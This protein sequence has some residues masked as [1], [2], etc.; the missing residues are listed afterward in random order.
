MKEKLTRARYSEW[1]ASLLGACLIA[2]GLGALLT[3]FFSP[4][5][6]YWLILVGIGSHSWGMYKTHL[7]NSR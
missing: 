3:Q 1:L 7:R 4:A 6:L 5:F 2:F